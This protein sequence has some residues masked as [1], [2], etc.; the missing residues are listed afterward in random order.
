MFINGS[1][2]FRCSAV[3]RQCQADH[4]VSSPAS[5]HSFSF[6]LGSSVFLFSIAVHAVLA[7]ILFLFSPSLCQYPS[8]VELCWALGK[9]RPDIVHY[10]QRF[11]G[12]VL[13][14]IMSIITWEHEGFVQSVKTISTYLPDIFRLTKIIFPFHFLLCKSKWM[15]V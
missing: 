8:H 7:L 15:R 14:G 13:Q 12:H 3:P 10:N 5:C 6:F 9:L 2:K 1:Y 11:P 4:S